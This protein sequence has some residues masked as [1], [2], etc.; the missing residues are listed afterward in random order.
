MSLDSEILADAPLVF[1][2][3]QETSGT[4]ATDSSAGGTNTGT[5]TSCTLNQTGPNNLKS[6]SFN[7]S[8]SNLQRAA[9]VI[10][11]LASG[12]TITLEAIVKGTT[13]AANACILGLSSN[14]ATA[15]IIAL[16][17]GG[18]GNAFPVFRMRNDGASGPD[19]FVSTPSGQSVIDGNW[20]HIV[21]TYDGTNIKTYC[22]G[23]LRSTVNNGALGTCT[24]NRTTAGALQRTTLSFPYTGN[25]LYSAVYNTALSQSRITAHY[26]AISASFPWLLL[27]EG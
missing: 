23:T 22:D 27:G 24:L 15:Q 2:K 26:N 18:T 19:A 6:V 12:S 21:G 10:G 25:I 11:N 8:T 3:M 5:Y 1:W 17:L 9:S 20:H 4:S 13:G 14:A 16:M 7:G